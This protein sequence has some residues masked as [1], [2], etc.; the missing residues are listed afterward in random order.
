MSVLA[1]LSIAVALSA[2]NFA[3]ALAVGAA[4][5]SGRAW[6]ALLE[7]P[8]AFGV[9]QFVAPMLG[10]LIGSQAAGVLRGYGS[11]VAFLILAFVGWR[12]LRSGW[13]AVADAP[14]AAPSLAATLALGVAT[15][16]DSLAVGFGLAMTG[17]NIVFASA[18]IG[19]VTAALSFLGIVVGKRLRR[20]F[21][22]QTR[23]VAGIVLVIVAIRILVTRG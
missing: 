23:V 17:V 20:D 21:G 1:I 12:M 4:Q 18:M 2:D 6:K 13:T 15:S 5:A 9:C 14:P 8:L 16:V 10:W 11:F 3:L 19:A 7:L 22:A